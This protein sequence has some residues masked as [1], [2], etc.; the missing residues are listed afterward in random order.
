M[1]FEFAT[2]TRIIFGPD[3]FRETGKLA[4]QMGNNALIVSG[5]DRGL[6]KKLADILSHHS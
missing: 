3:K 1:F 6:T 5:L 4:K 2:A